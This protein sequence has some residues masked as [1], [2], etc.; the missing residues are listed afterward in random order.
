[1]SDSYERINLLFS[2]GFTYFWRKAMLNKIDHVDN[3]SLEIMDLMTG[4]GETWDLLKAKFPSARLSGLDISDGM[5]KNARKKNK[6]KY[7]DN[8]IILKDNVLD[9]SLDS[10]KYDLVFSAFGLKTF[11]KQQVKILAQE[12]KRILKPKGAFA[13]IEISE[14]ENIFFNLFYRI[15]IG[16]ITP[17]ITRLLLGDPEEY[18][19]LWEYT[20]RYKNSQWVADIFNDVGLE[21][22]YDE[23]FFGC[24]SGVSGSKT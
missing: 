13:L 21:T 10:N 15:Y 9:N 7:S 8:I 5:L 3:N 23:Y 14:P 19:L 12:I 24:A 4:M 22:T 18:K 2:F 16:K 20:K 17:Q 11:N 1:M 6:A